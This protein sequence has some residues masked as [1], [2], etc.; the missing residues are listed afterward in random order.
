MRVISST[1]R[2]DIESQNGTDVDLIF[3]T[4]THPL[5][6]GPRCVNSDVAD[7]LYNGNTFFGVGAAISLVSDDDS[8]P[9]AQFNVE[10]VDRRLS[11]ALLAISDAPAIA[12]QLLRRTD[13][14]NS[15]PRNPLATP[16]VQYNAPMLFLR[17]VQWN[18]VTMSGDLGSYD[19]TTE[20]WP[21]NRT[22]PT[23]TPALFR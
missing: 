15:I 21:N 12:I 2:T 1:Y 9:R 11:A 16:T 18:A 20:S 23:D 14:D 6:D 17:N 4:I 7:Y 3:A 19:L 5:L 8:P 13:F 22:T 10:V